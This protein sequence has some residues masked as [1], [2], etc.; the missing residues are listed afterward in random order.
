MRFLRQVI[1]NPNMQHLNYS[2]TQI[3]HKEILQFLDD[4]SAYYLGINAIKYNNA[5]DT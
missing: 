3:S 4:E 2:L 1:I 5:Q